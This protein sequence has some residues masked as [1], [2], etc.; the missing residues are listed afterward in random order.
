MLVCTLAVPL[1]MLADSSGSG[2][3]YTPSF[4]LG[5]IIPALICNARK[6]K[7]IGGWLMLFYWQLYSGLLIT[8]IFFATNI[9]SYVPENFDSSTKFRLF[10]ASVVPGLLLFAVKCAVAT[11]LLSARTWDMLR[12][13]RLVML[14]ELLADVIGS[15]IDVAY[16]PDNVAINLVLTIIPGLIWLAYMFR[17]K[18][19]QHIFYLQDW[20]VAVDSIYPLKLTMAT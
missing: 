9:Q 18:R 12:L 13:L 10:L 4:P 19:V 17:S 11:L 15:V 8:G 5:G 7:P 6:R 2:S 3:S 14:G 1:S 20:D 16:F